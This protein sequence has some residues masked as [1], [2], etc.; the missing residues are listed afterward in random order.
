MGSVVQWIPLD[1]LEVLASTLLYRRVILH[2]VVDD[3]LLVIAQV[4]KVLRFLHPANSSVPSFLVHAV[5][6]HKLG[7]MASGA[8]RNYGHQSL[9]INEARPD[10]NSVFNPVG[11]LIQISLLLI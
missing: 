5:L 1:V 8:I 4:P 7:R 9:V 2:K 11:I 10:V 3:D 6:R